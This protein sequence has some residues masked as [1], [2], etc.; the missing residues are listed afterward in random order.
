MAKAKEGIRNPNPEERLQQHINAVRERTRFVWFCSPSSKLYQLINPAT[1]LSVM[2]ILM[3]PI[4][5]ICIYLDWPWLAFKWMG[6]SASTDFLDGWT[7]KVLGCITKFGAWLDPIADKLK[8]VVIGVVSLPAMVAAFI[9]E[10]VT[11]LHSEPVRE[12][13]EKKAGEHHFISNWSK[14]VTAGQFIVLSLL[15]LF[16]MSSSLWY[17]FVGITFLRFLI[18]RKEYTLHVVGTGEHTRCD[19]IPNLITYGGL[20]LIPVIL[21]LSEQNL[22]VIGMYIVGLL[23]LSYRLSVPDSLLGNFIVIAKVSI[24]YLYAK[25][26]TTDLFDGM[27]ARQLDQ[28]SKI[29]EMLDTVRDFGLMFLGLYLWAPEAIIPATAGQ[30][31]AFYFFIKLKGIKNQ[32]TIPKLSRWVTGLLACA[33]VILA[34]TSY[35]GY[36]PFNIERQWLVYIIIALPFARAVVYCGSWLI[37]FIGREMAKDMLAESEVW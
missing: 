11:K 10:I 22:H 25:A 29:G 30:G 17:L 14:W 37:A 19:T 6:V 8:L 21:F 27:A 13:I 31:I 15:C 3:I 5:M 35:I 32:H 12:Q 34:I 18:Y 33:M 4:V 2:R 16:P 28:K 7:A 23:P 26:W 36:N 9:I 20:T 24:L 1:L